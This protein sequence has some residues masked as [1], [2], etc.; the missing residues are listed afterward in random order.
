MN[1][2]RTLIVAS[3]ERTG[4]TYLCRLLKSTG[5]AGEPDEYLNDWWI[6]T[7][8]PGFGIRTCKVL[9]LPKVAGYGLGLLKTPGGYADVA[10]SGVPRYLHAIEKAHRSPNGVFA[11]KLHWKHFAFATGSWGLDFP[12]A[13]PDVTWVHLWRE[14]RFAQA[15][16]WLRALQTNHWNTEDPSIG[17][18][19]YDSVRLGHLVR[20]AI[21]AKDRWDRHFETFENPPLELTYEYLNSDPVGV[22]DQVLE[23]LGEKTTVVPEVSIMVQRDRLNQEWMERMVKD[24]PD[25]VDLRYAPPVAG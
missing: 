12:P 15:V 5:V 24:H 13:G 10:P 4:S 1:R 8:G 20:Q 11:L 25:L 16:S 19:V 22:V 21:A 17:E 3:M 6:L 9:S 18:P 7:K 23:M 2:D 14:D